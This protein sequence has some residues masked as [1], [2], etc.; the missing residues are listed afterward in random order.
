MI[1]EYSRQGGESCCLHLRN[2]RFEIGKQSL[3]ITV[4]WNLISYLRIIL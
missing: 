2:V 4:F 3:F 1:K